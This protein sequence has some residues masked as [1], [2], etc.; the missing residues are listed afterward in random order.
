MASTK[1]KKWGLIIL[2]AILVLIVGA[3]VGFQAAGEAA[4]GVGS[5]LQ[6]LL[7][8]PKKR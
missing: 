2:A 4:K 6:Q 1:A 5:A 7:G 8:G 3:I